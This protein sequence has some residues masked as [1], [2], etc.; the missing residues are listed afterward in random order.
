MQV[1]DSFRLRFHFMT[2]ADA[3]LFLQLDSDPE[4]MRYIN[5]GKVS[6]PESI[7]DWYIPRLEK[8]A[9]Q[10]KGWGLWGASEKESGDFIGWILVRPMGFFGGERDDEDLELGWR[11]IREAWGKGYGTEA[12]RAVM[13]ALED[14]GYE[15]FTAYAMKE[16]AASIN[17][18]QKIGMEFLREA[19]DPEDLDLMLA[20]YSRQK[21]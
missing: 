18:M 21:S 1:P 14:N 3:E 12:A 8:Y 15:K 11:F 13:A 9:D 4:V 19:P 5:G 17:I 6:T 2:A 10:D 7:Q 16:N 20:Y